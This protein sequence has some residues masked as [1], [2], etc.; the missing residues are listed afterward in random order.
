LNAVLIVSALVQVVFHR[1]SGTIFLIG[2]VA[3]S[4]SFLRIFT[5]FTT[6]CTLSILFAISINHFDLATLLAT[7]SHHISVRSVS[8]GFSTI[9]F[10]SFQAVQ[11]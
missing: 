4:A 9:A 3:S 6:F 8:A 1:T 7:H 10:L 11:Y 2:Y 5:G